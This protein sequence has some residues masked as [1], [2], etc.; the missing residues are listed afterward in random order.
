MSLISPSRAPSDVP[1]REGRPATLVRERRYVEEVISGQ[2]RRA[3]S[4]RAVYA[5]ITNV[6][7]L[8]GEVFV[9]GLDGYGAFAD[10]KGDAFDGPVAHLVGVSRPS[11]TC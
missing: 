10:G 1:C 8:F 2:H 3:C 5:F 11:N 4:A 6:Q 7:Q 9:G